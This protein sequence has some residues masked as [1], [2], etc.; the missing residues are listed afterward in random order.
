MSWQIWGRGVRRLGKRELGPVRCPP[1]LELSFADC[2]VEKCLLKPDCA[3][4]LSSFCLAS[5][6]AGGKSC[7]LARMVPRLGHPVVSG[8]IGSARCTLSTA[9]GVLCQ[10][11]ACLDMEEAVDR[12]ASQSVLPSC[13]CS[14]SVSLDSEQRG[15]ATICSPS[16]WRAMDAQ[17]EQISLG[18]CVGN[19]VSVQSCF[20]AAWVRSQA[21]CGCHPS[22]PLP[23]P[24]PLPA[25]SRAA[26]PAGVR[27]CPLPSH[28][29]QKCCGAWAGL[30]GW[31]CSFG[32]SS[33][34]AGRNHLPI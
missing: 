28:R 20:T 27:G 7:A 9:S 31:L 26:L 4:L 25:V 2:W 8:G 30:T 15:G 18:M 21:G 16:L 13:P 3:V 10:R 24:C 23:V 12:G 34:S 14:P 17:Q 6:M 11:A 32:A 29:S 22:A 19:A 1:F 33:A 5:G